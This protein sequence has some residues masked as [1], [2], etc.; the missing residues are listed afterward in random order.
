LLR[1]VLNVKIMAE[2]EDTPI[3]LDHAT[4]RLCEDALSMAYHEK[5][6]TQTLCF[7]CIN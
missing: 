4:S 5:S 6:L 1:R 2:P 7:Y 3:L